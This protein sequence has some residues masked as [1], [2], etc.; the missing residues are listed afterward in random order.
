[1][2]GGGVRD[3]EV[4]GTALTGLSSPA[5]ASSTSMRASLVQR[6]FLPSPLEEA[7]GPARLD[8]FARLRGMFTIAAIGFDLSIYFGFR[9]SAQFDP[10]V[11]AWFAWLN[12]TL[13]SIS[14]ALCFFMLRKRSRWFATASLV[15]LTL[16][17]FTSVVWIQ[18]TGS[19]SSY[20]LI[21]I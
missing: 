20:F 19:V 7:P 8:A 9:D 15:G 13:L 4:S 21:V 1:M 5:L 12:V 11:L 18:L 3:P 16:E 14:S 6:A 2:S 17:L 10:R